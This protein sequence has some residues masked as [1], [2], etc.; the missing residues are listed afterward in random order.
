MGS[1][2]IT[3]QKGQDQKEHIGVPAYLSI[4]PDCIDRC[5]K[6]ETVLTAVHFFYISDA[7]RLNVG[8]LNVKAC[9]FRGYLIYNDLGFVL[10]TI[11]GHHH[12]SRNTS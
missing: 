4:S 9:S 5:Q 10:S 6:W 2:R 3:Q 11:Q 7:K 12:R 8:N 1:H